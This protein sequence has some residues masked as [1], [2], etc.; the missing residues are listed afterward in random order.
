MQALPEACMEAAVDPDAAERA[1]EAWKPPDAP[2]VSEPWTPNMGLI[3]LL[4]QISCIPP[5]R[6]SVVS[7]SNLDTGLRLSLTLTDP[8]IL[9]PDLSYREC[10]YF[11]E[12][13]NA[14]V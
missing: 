5:F 9:D 6:S 13:I 1:R 3:A 12:S 14:I 10:H 4:A 7:Y 11:S 8:S 2:L